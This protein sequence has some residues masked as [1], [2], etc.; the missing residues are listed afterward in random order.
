MKTSKQNLSITFAFLL[1]AFVFT[2]CAGTKLLKEPERF[3]TTSSLVT[4]SDEQMAMSLDWVVVR[5]GPGT[6]A[7][8]A[9]WD[10]Y[11][12]RVQNLGDDVIQVNSI[13]LLDSLGTRIEPGQNRKQ[14]VIGSKE[15][16]RRYKGS[17][18]KVQAGAGVGTLVTAG[19]VTG[20]ATAALVAS[21]PLALSSGAAAAATGGLI[22][23]PVFAVGSVMRGL[24]NSK[25]NSQIELR[26]T[27]LPAALEEEE[28]SLDIFFPLTPSPRQIELTYVDSGGEHV[29]IV[30][31]H[32]ALAGLN[33]PHAN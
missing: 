11:L 3:T 19:A 12:I 32:E 33:L 13:T 29:V 23:L 27:L 7:K 18:I 16:V 10:E 9:D 25:V 15:A 24:N 17:G 5:D 21:G 6:W 20:V 4:G 28:K 2:G 30:D 14:L 31:T 26:Q 1:S 22:L 8:N